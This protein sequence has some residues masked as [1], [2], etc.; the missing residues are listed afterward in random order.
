V[1]L[2][3][4]LSI[5]AGKIVA[6]TGDWE[7]TKGQ[8]EI[9]LLQYHFSPETF[10][11]FRKYYGK[12]ISEIKKK[13]YENSI[14]VGKLPSCEVSSQTF[15]EY[16]IEC[17]AENLSIKKINIYQIVKKA[18]TKFGLIIPKIVVKNTIIPNAAAAGP[19]ARFG[20][21]MI[22]T[23]IMNQLEEDELLSVIGHEMSHLKSHDP[24]IMSSLSSLEL[25]LRFYVFLPYITSFGVIGFWVYFIFAIGLIY[26]FGKFLEGRADLDS[27]KIIGQPKVMAEA[28]RK[29]GFR[30]LFPLFKREPEFRDYR[31]TEWLRF[32]PHPPAYHRI[33]QLEKIENPNKIEHT[34]LKTIKDN[35]SAFLNP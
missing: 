3:L 27:A 34:F 5:F 24:L 29:I 28:L 23:G 26:F 12:K 21:V 17:K 32:D 1:A 15:S 30:R 10:E 2:L 22:T 9:I 20:T 8:E 35:I 25:L 16:G 7:I 33:G 31:R 18:A 13:I 11:I 6:K 4:I 19:T 14:A